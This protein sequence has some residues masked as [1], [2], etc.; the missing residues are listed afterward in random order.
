MGWNGDLIITFTP[1]VI[2][3]KGSMDEVH[4]AMWDIV[5]QAVEKPVENDLVFGLWK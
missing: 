3:A 1:Q 5:N 4:S 2:D